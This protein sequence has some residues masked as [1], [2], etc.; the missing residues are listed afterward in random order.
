MTDKIKKSTEVDVMNGGDGLPDWMQFTI[1]IGMFGA[2]LW[3]LYL[4][5]LLLIYSFFTTYNLHNIYNI[6]QTLFFFFL[7]LSK[8]KVNTFS[9]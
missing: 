9:K 1:T 3:I 4:L 8:P 6:N 7:I 2:L 5:F